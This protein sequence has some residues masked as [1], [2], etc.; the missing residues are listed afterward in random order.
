MQ[1]PLQNGKYLQLDTVLFVFTYIYMLFLFA[2]LS[3]K[4]LRNTAMDESI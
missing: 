2:C 4:A 3:E 1:T